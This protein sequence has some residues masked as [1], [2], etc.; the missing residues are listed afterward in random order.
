MAIN[1][2]ITESGGEE[3]EKRVEKL[4]ATVR[5]M[6][7]AL[8]A[9]LKQMVL[10]KAASGEFGK[11]EPCDCGDPQCVKQQAYEASQKAEGEEIGSGG[12]YL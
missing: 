7:T 9:V 2:T 11:L 4:E 10:S 1:V 5:E 8:E 6:L 12:A 3:L